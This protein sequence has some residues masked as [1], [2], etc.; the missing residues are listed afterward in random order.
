MTTWA[1]LDGASMTVQDDGRG[2]PVDRFANSKISALEVG[3]RAEG[4][5]L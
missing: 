5:G 1:K 2:I 3:V 4:A